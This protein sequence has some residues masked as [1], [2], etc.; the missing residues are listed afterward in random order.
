MSKLCL[1]QMVNGSQHTQWQGLGQEEHL[2]STNKLQAETE[3]FYL[4]HNQMLEELEKWGEKPCRED[5]V[6]DLRGCTHT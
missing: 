1:L 2:L 6:I 5:C 3:L 4:V